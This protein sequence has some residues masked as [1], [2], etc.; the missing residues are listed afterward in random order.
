VQQ[1]GSHFNPA[2]PRRAEL[3]AFLRYLRLIFYATGK[4]A[5][6]DMGLCKQGCGFACFGR[7]LH[8]L[9][10]LRPAVVYSRCQVAAAPHFVLI[11]EVCVCP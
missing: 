2:W 5:C 1:T 4:K 7:H 6:A 8:M 10:V 3:Y 9:G 11:F